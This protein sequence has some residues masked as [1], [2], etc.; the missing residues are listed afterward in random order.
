M[1]FALE[2]WMRQGPRSLRPE[3]GMSHPAVQEYSGL[4]QDRARPFCASS[5]GDGH[6]ATRVHTRCSAVQR[7][8]LQI[9]LPRTAEYVDGNLPVEQPTI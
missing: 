5:A 6:A 4:A 1:S 2:G 9:G 3:L 8:V 7:R